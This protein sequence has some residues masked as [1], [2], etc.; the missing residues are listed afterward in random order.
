MRL[1]LRTTSHQVPKRRRAAPG[2]VA[3]H[4]AAQ[5]RSVW[6]ARRQ[7]GARGVP[8]SAHGGLGDIE[9]LGNLLARRSGE[10]PHLDDERLAFAQGLE[11]RLEELGARRQQAKSAEARE[12]FTATR[13]IFGPA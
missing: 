12:C 9:H 13:W 10:E 3:L 8:I 11:V 4:D 7:P 5:P 6:D 2:P 1:P